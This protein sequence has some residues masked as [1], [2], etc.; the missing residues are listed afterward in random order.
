[1][2]FWNEPHTNLL[3]HRGDDVSAEDTVHF[4]D[5]DG[6][7]VLPIRG[8][9]FIERRTDD[10]KWVFPE[11]P[12]R[13]R[14]IEGVVCFISNQS[15]A[16]AE[17]DRGLNEQ[18][19]A[20]WKE[21]GWKR[22]PWFFGAFVKDYQFRKPSPG[23][24]HLFRELSG[25][26]GTPTRY[27]GDAIGRE[28][29]HSACDRHLAENAGM[30]ICPP[31]TFFLGKTIEIPREDWSPLRDIPTDATIIL[32]S[33]LDIPDDI[34][35]LLMRGAP[36]SGKSNLAERIQEQIPH[37]WVVVSQ[38]QYKSLGK[39]LGVAQNLLIA[40]RKVIIDRTHPDEA[41]RKPC[42]QL[43]RELHKKAGIVSLETPTEI[44]NHLNHYRATKK[45]T[46]PIPAVVYRKY[47]KCASTPQ[48]GAEGLDWMASVPF[49]WEGNEEKRGDLCRWF[50]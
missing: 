45:R 46:K 20:A 2:D 40:G 43:A 14:N 30:E 8:K 7:V 37:Q 5:W 17:N 6:T 50:D 21:I 15:K 44:Q 12:D 18:L 29:D 35:V 41:S 32:G 31:E 39:T 1:M 24:I 26:K 42:I 22:E 19:R 11:V 3:I 27:I 23:S 36:A 9:L 25:W 48:E 4:M 28:G 13:L 34:Q 16:N 38:D 49:V 33:G 47:H 10:W